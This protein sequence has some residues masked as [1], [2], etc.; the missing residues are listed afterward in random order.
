[1]RT[2]LHHHYD[3]L[4]DNEREFV[5]DAMKEIFDLQKLNVHT[6]T[7]GYKSPPLA[8]DDRAEVAT[9][10]IARWV[11]ESRPK[12]SALDVAIMGVD[13][14]EHFAAIAPK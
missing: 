11:I 2:N 6:R 7:P 4:T 1:M 12:A 8:G 3:Q 9:D 14:A 10:A 5:D 13:A